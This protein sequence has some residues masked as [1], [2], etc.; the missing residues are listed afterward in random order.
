GEAA[1]CRQRAGTGCGFQ[2]CSSI[3]VVPSCSTRL[4]PAPIVPSAVAPI[5]T[6]RCNFSYEAGI[7]ALDFSPN[8]SWTP[9]LRCPEMLLFEGYTLDIACGTLR[10]ADRDLA[11][12]PKSFEVL[13]YLLENAERIVTKEELIKAV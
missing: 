5:L 13:R 4:E 6:E 9:S 12:R 1:C 11:L 3:H 2:E 8:P 10:T 7:F